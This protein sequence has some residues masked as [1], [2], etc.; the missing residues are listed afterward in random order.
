M[1]S[2]QQSRLIVV[3]VAMQLRLLHVTS[4]VEL[5]AK[6][7]DLIKEMISKLGLEV[8]SSEVQSLAWDVISK[9]SLSADIG[10]SVTSSSVRGDHWLDELSIDFQ[11]FNRFIKYL[12]LKK[13]WIDTTA[14]F[15]MAV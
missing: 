1:I 2:N 3:K 7:V 13:D 5:N 10:V 6:A 8:T 15:M 12:K 11:Y 9:L 4:F 14:L